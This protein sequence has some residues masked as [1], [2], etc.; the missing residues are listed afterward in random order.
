MYN[1][2]KVTVNGKTYEAEYIN[3]EFRGVYGFRDGRNWG[4]PVRHNQ[5]YELWRKYNY[6]HE[7]REP[8][9]L[10]AAVI[11]AAK[12]KHIAFLVGGKA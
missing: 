9:K 10:V 7:S 12:I 2:Y 5:R 11:E 4:G 8:S 1:T 3:G 6:Y